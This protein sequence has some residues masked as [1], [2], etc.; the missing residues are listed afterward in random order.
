MTNGNM[1]TGSL[2]AS[3]QWVG[4]GGPQVSVVVVET[5]WLIPWQA[6]SLTGFVNIRLGNDL[7]RLGSWKLY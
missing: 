1:C 5:V 3:P 2:S 6:Q 7:Y 4:G